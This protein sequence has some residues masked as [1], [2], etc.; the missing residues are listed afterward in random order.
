MGNR[1]DWIYRGLPVR[2][3]GGFAVLLYRCLLPV[4]RGVLWYIKLP[5]GRRTGRFI[6]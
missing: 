3:A 6:P 1:P 5:A 2:K 4:A